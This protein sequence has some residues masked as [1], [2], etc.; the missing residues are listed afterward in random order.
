VVQL[1]VWFH[2]DLSCTRPFCAPAEDRRSSMHDSCMLAGLPSGGISTPP[3]TGLAGHTPASAVLSLHFLRKPRGR[4]LFIS[5]LAALLGALGPIC[6]LN[7]AIAAAYVDT[8]TVHW[9][10]HRCLQGG[11]CRT[12]TIWAT[13]LYSRPDGPLLGLLPVAGPACCVMGVCDYGVGC[14]DAL[15]ASMSFVERQSTS[16][17]WDA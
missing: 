17:Y 10:G 16:R 6:I 11:S 15:E 7:R 14:W 1:A 4:L 9:R 8:A 2:G 5:W 13:Q 3:S 12:Q